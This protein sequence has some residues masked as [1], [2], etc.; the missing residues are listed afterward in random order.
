[1]QATPNANTYH[2]LELHAENI[3][4]IQVIDIT[5][6]DDMVVLG[7]K[8]EQG[9]SSTLDCIEMMLRGAKAFSE[10]PVRQG[11]AQG[12]VRGTLGTPEGVVKF[13]ISRVIQKNGTHELVVTD[14]TTGEAIRSPQKF[15]DALVSGLSFDPMGFAL[16]ENKKRIEILKSL[17]NFDFNALTRKREKAYKTRADV[18]SRLRDKEGENQARPYDPM[19]TRE[20]KDDTALKEQI[21]QNEI[22][23]ANIKTLNDNVSRGIAKV[24]ELQEVIAE[25]QK[26]IA[27][28]DAYIAQAG[29]Q[30]QQL[31]AIPEVDVSAELAA[32]QAHN[33]AVQ[34]NELA[35]Q[36]LDAKLALEAESLQLTNEIEGCDRE[37]DEA[38]KKAQLPV[39]GLTFSDEGVYF[40]G[41]PF[42]QLSQAVRIKVSIAMGIALNPE[43]KV[44]LVRQGAYLDEDNLEIIRQMA[45]EH[46]MQ[47][48]LERVGTG[49]EVSLV[50]SD[51]RIIEDRQNERSSGTE[52]PRINL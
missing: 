1:M 25:A 4:R 30:L 22:R 31:M 52:Q 45:K 19:L 13:R 41:I 16:L 29:P 48:W 44:L 39:S 2:L 32:I 11:Q 21:K 24:K 18:N 51:G 10:E 33:A 37:R 34:G 47:V 28:I 12:V 17:I 7:G 50:F 42:E 46:R 49:K 20:L 36:I 26:K 23:N 38:I 27:E 15:L 43:L 9:K 35:R 5:P 6:G 3:H 14:E 8:N 40:N